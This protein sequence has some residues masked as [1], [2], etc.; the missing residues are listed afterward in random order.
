MAQ[1]SPDLDRIAKNLKRGI[2]LSEED[3]AALYRAMSEF[4]RIFEQLEQAINVA[5]SVL[6]DVCREL[7][8]NL[9]PSTIEILAKLL[10]NRGE[11]ADDSR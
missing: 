10:E 4:G 11:E 6:T 5:A 2:A 8:T 7:I 3:K 1:L 9:P